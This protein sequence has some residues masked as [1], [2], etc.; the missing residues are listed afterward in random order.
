MGNSYAEEGSVPY[1]I[2]LLTP[3]QTRADALHTYGYPS[4][5]T[6]NIDQLA[7][8]GTVFTRAYSAAPWTTPS[9]GSIFTGLY[10]TVHGM[11]LPP[12]QGCGPYITHP[13]VGA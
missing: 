13:M 12:Y 7:R 6:P 1:N 5:D 10:P 8:E 4:L 3:D 2:I 11:T 9:F